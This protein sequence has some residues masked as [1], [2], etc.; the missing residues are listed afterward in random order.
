MTWPHCFTTPS[1]PKATEEVGDS[2]QER[3]CFLL[4]GSELK[5]YHHVH[6]LARHFYHEIF[7]SVLSSPPLRHF[8][9]KVLLSLSHSPSTLW[10]EQ[11]HRPQP[12]PLK[13]W[14]YCCYSVGKVCFCLI[15]VHMSQQDKGTTW[16][17]HMPMFFSHKKTGLV[18]IVA[19]TR[20][21]VL[22]D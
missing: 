9:L 19:A 4:W 21:S 2:E 8:Q 18:F 15:R 20:Q 16:S 5:G 12:H 11:S 17:Q 13:S 3:V 14:N 7:D 10:L 6:Q 22:P 1:Q